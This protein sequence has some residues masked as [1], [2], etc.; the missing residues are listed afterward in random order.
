MLRS[1]RTPRAGRHTFKARPPDPAP[2]GRLRR[3]ASAV[4]VLARRAV[5]PRRRRRHERPPGRRAADRLGH[6][7]QQRQRQVRRRAR[8]RHRQRH[9]RTAVRLQQ[10]HRAAVAVSPPPAAATS[11][12]TT[13]TTP[14]R[15]GTSPTSRPPT[16]PPSTCG[17]RRR[18]QPAVAGRWRRPAGPTTSSTATAASAWTCPRASTADSVQLVQYTCNG[19]AAQSLPPVGDPQP[20]QHRRPPDTRTSAR[21]CASST[22]RCPP[23][24]I[25][26]QLE[27][28]LQRSRRP[29]SSAPQ[30][31]ALLFKPG[32]LQRRRQRRLLHP[33][34]WASACRPDA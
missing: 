14:T 22:R 16:T 32:T 30:R 13:A 5:Q 8:G 24:T 33:G 19:T 18:Q 7:G 25:Q 6:R 9:R 2:R 21:T 1:Q 28:G 17:L 23:S 12:S 27:H 10:H 3:A 4:S 29:T 31:Y 34:R 26:S 15:S 20:T 11:G